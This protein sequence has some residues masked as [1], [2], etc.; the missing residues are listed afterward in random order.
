MSKL[1][2]FSLRQT[3]LKL[4]IPYATLYSWIDKGQCPAPAHH[5][6]CRRFYELAQ[7]TQ[8]EKELDS[9]FRRT[10][11]VLSLLG[12]D[13]A[14]YLKAKEAKEAKEAK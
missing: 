5:F 4:K 3:A 14:A 8:M 12:Y 13:R 2:L 6:G 10:P 11:N 7:V 9:Y 1:E